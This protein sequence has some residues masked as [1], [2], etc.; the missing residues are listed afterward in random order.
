MFSVVFS[1]GLKISPGTPGELVLQEKNMF[2]IDFL[3]IVLSFCLKFITAKKI[4]DF[5]M[6]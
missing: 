4:L 5:S 6:Q 1:Y 3:Q 2:I